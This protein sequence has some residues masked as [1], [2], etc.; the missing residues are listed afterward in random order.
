MKFINIKPGNED[1]TNNTD[2]NVRHSW[3]SGNK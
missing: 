2:P 1:P 3:S